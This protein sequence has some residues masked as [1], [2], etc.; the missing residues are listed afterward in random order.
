[1]TLAALRSQSRTNIPGDT[2]ICGRFTAN[3]VTITNVEGNKFIVD[4]SGTGL[5]RVRFGTS[6]NDLTTF[7]GL[8]GCFATAVVAAP[9]ANGRFVV[10]QQIFTNPS[11][12]VASVTL[13]TVD[14]GGALAD[15]AAGDG[16]CFEMIVRDTEVRV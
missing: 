3:G 5:Y 13:G 7:M 4:K 12:M 11:G 15:L 16:I 2:R 8:V 10:L 14:A 6:V 1:M 9:G